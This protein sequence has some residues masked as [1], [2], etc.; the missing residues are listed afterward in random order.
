MCLSCS[1]IREHKR[2]ASIIAR[3][4]TVTRFLERRHFLPLAK[5]DNRCV[6]RLQA[7]QRRSDSPFP[8][9]SHTI[10]FATDYIHSNTAVQ[11]VCVRA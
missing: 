7:L 1:L 9:S 3:T 2:N 8:H 6:P 4:P 5:A 10:V 11:R